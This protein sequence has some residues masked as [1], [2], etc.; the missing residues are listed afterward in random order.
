MLGNNFKQSTQLSLSGLFNSIH[1]FAELNSLKELIIRGGN[2]PSFTLTSSFILDGSDWATYLETII[3]GD[4]VLPNLE[5][6]SISHIK[7]LRTLELG[8]FCATNCTSFTMEEIPYLASISLAE[9]A[10]R[11]IS[12]LHS[13]NFP[14]LSSIQIGDFA[15]ECGEEFVVDNNPQLTSIQ[16]GDNCFRNGKAFLLANVNQLTRLVVGS[17]NPSKTASSLSEVENLVI[18]GRYFAEWR[19]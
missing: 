2:E 9:G 15:L 16:I 6:L 1:S 7:A 10:L 4:N 19:M 8:A 12:R 17:L 11:T 5:S 13:S 3:L 18:Q 14:Q